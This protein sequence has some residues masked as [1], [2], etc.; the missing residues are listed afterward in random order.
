MR[1]SAL[2]ER[3]RD[4][5]DA[6]LELSTAY[7]VQVTFVVCSSAPRLCLAHNNTTRSLA[8]MRHS[9]TRTELTRWNSR[10]ESES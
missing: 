2:N 5:E 3:V 4:A 7:E 8:S 6:L 1:S 9:W 10:V